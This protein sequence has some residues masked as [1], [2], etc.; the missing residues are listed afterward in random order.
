MQRGPVVAALL[1]MFGGSGFQFGG[2]LTDTYASS[3]AAGY[4]ST[5]RLGKASERTF[6]ARIGIGQR[7][8]QLSLV[9]QVRHARQHRVFLSWQPSLPT[10]LW[11]EDLIAGYN[12][13]RRR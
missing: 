4:V 10:T 5:P 8:D 2:A 13:Y 6:F 7:T 3:P 1:L 12:V 11:S 9:S